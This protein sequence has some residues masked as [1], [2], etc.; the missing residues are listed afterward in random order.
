MSLVSELKRRNVLRMAVLYVIAS[1]LIMQVAE[2]I[3]ALA[4]LPEWIGP[5][6]LGLLAIG[7][8]IALI[9]SWFYEIT[10]DGI[11]LERDVDPA[12]SITHV[13]GRRLDFLVISLLCSALILFAYDKWWIGP[14]PDKSIAVLPFENLSSDPDQEYFSEGIS[15]ELLNLLAQVPELMVISRSSAFSFKGKEVD[16]PTVAKQLNVAY[17][18]EGSVRKMGNR[19]R[20]TAQLIE[21]RTDSHLWSNTYDRD[22]DDIFAVQDDIAESVVA[23]LQLTLL[24]EVPDVRRTDTEAYSL[25]LQAQHVALQETPEAYRDAILLLRRVLVIDESYAPA[26]SALSGAISREVGFSLRPFSE[27]TESARIAA[28][29]ALELDPNLASAHIEM[30]RIAMTYDWDY[31]SAI[32]HLKLVSAKEARIPRA[33]DLARTFGRYDLAV[34]WGQ[35]AI[36]LD[37]VSP[38][39]HRVFAVSLIAVGRFAEAEVALQKSLMLSPRSIHTNAILAI[40]RLEQGMPEAAMQ[41]AEESPVEEFQLYL[42][43]MAMFAMGDVRGSDEQLDL[44]IQKFAE[45]SASSIATIYAFREEPDPAFRWL[46]KAYENHDAAVSAIRFNPPFRKLDHHPKMQPFLSKIGLSDEQLATIELDFVLSE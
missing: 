17:V 12:R 39:A 3:I 11:S 45:E 30:A 34:D 27:G 23:E 2:V 37:P 44:Y 35:Q 25:Y 15:E 32:A 33:A 13:T 7:F 26:W 36:R 10:P 21:A 19:V 46:E 24:G 43:S 9:F 31:V 40:L 6:T 16:T 5:I 14:P 28:K 29:K 18:L 1:W 20:V 41:I 38:R 8:P 4:N 22:M 42:Q